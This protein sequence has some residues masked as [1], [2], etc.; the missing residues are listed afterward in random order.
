MKTAQ[1]GAKI[2]QWQTNNSEGFATDWNILLTGY[3]N[4]VK[5]AIQCLPVCL[6]LG[7]LPHKVS[8]DG[9]E[10]GLVEEDGRELV[11]PDH[12]DLGLLEGSSP[13]VQRGHSIFRHHLYRLLAGRCGEEGEPRSQTGS[14]DDQNLSFVDDI[15]VSLEEP[16][17][18]FKSV[19]AFLAQTN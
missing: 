17:L 1:L 3:K 9:A 11:A 7:H 10:G 2:K 5:Q 12:V 13:P 8:A 16:R 15:T 18:C 19:L 4:M 14:Y 6:Q